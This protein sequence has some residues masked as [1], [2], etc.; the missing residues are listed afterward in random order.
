MSSIATPTEGLTKLLERLIGGRPWRYL[1]SS[2]A[3][4]VKS[5]KKRIRIKALETEHFD[6]YENLN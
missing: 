2:A 5:R 1:R 4:G 6:S 3:R